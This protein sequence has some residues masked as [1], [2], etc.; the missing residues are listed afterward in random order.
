MKKNRTSTA[1][2]FI[3]FI[4]LLTDLVYALFLRDLV[5]E[6]YKG[7]SPAWLNS[8]IDIFYPRF[9]VE[10]YR[11]NFSFFQDKSDQVILRFSLVVITT[12]ILF[13]CKSKSGNFREFL[14][15]YWNQ[16]TSISNINILRILFFTFL[17]I[18]FKDVYWDLMSLSKA[19]VFY[20]PILLNKIFNLPFPSDNGILILYTLFITSCLACIFNFRAVLFSTIALVNF[21]LIQGYIFSFEKL[22][23]GFATYTYAAMLMPFLLCQLSNTKT[24]NEIAIYDWVLPL[25]R[26]VI[27]MCYLFSGLEKLFASGI[28]WIHPE[29]FKA[30]LLIHETPLGLKIAAS[31]FLCSLFAIGTILFQLSFITI[32]PF[33]K[34]KWFILPLGIAFHV[35]T[36]LIMDVGGYS[37]PWILVYIFFIDW[38]KLAILISEKFILRSH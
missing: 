34:L 5:Y 29:S 22:D 28:Y 21:I 17:L 24:N 27:C 8:F 31:D 38:S 3:L 12:C 36:Y 10:K 4:V 25:I 35:G 7:T 37:N 33:P 14:S 15:N 9:K 30:H 2:V 18:M 23:H 20:R 16:K 26:L 13:Y 32:I 11:F 19:K 1:I 6:S